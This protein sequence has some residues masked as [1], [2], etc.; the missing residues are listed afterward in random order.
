MFHFTM[1]CAA[2]SVVLWASLAQAAPSVQ[3]WLRRPAESVTSG[4]DQRGNLRNVDLAGLTFDTLETYDIQYEAMGKYRGLHLRDLIAAYKPLPGSIDTLILHFDNG[5][6]IPVTL[7]M[8]RGDRRIFVALEMLRDGKWTSN[9]PS[10]IRIAP[11]SKDE[12]PITFAAN[13]IVVG[14][15][16]SASKNQFTPWRHASSLVGIEFVEATGLINSFVQEK[17]TKYQ[18]GKY[19]YLNRCQF[20]HAISGQG[21]HFGPDFTG[22]FDLEAKKGWEKILAKVSKAE[23]NADA[24][25]HAMPKQSDFSKSDAKELFGW[26]KQSKTHPFALYRATYNRDIK[27]D[28]PPTP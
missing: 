27:W 11:G 15:D 26:V 17:A 18:P 8:L 23:S 20:C 22:A 28:N 3:I 12:R 14:S 24:M 1:L 5:M 2:A 4:G 6:L 13:K 9:F 16:W 7:S 25:K 10:S 21:A 19:V